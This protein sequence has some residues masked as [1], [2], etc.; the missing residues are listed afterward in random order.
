M[1]RRKSGVELNFDGLT[2]SVTNL[3]GSLI[4]LVVL[5]VAVTSPEI[6]GVEKPP[7]PDN[8]AGAEQPV[9]ML[10]ERMRA[11]KV[12]ID[13]V[14]QGIKRIELRLP[15]IDAEVIELQQQSDELFKASSGKTA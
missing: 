9:D 11:M 5:V 6:A 14:D 10:L 3:V 7:P 1:A 8:D 15:E 13:N 4:L 12:K 2:D